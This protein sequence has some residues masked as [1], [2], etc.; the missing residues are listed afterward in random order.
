M[1][2]RAFRSAAA[3]RVVDSFSSWMS[4][5]DDADELAAADELR[6]VLDRAITAYADGF[7]VG[8]NLDRA[9]QL[10]GDRGANTAD[11]A[12]ALGY[13]RTSP[14]GWHQPERDIQIV[15]TGHNMGSAPESS[16]D[17][18]VAVVS[19]MIDELPGVTCAIDARYISAQG[20][21]VTCDCRGE[22]ECEQEVKELLERAW[23]RYCD[24]EVES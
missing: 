11:V 19:N 18:F 4:D 1:S 3:R 21:S 23:E 16:F 8:E 14:R 7:D 13:V 2:I 22:C 17:E 15:L 9:S 6:D 24:G 20:D 10:E 12:T 5:V